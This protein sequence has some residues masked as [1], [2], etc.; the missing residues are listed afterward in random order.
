VPAIDALPK[1]TSITA[2]LP[3]RLSVIPDPIVSD[4]KART[5]TLGPPLWVTVCGLGSDW[6]QV[7]PDQL[8]P[9]KVRVPEQLRFTAATGERPAS[10]GA[11]RL[12]GAYP[13]DVDT[14]AAGIPGL[15]RA[16]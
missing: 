13:N 6:P 11:V 16:H 7:V 12:A 9:L 8:V 4:W 15:C 2:W 1:T 10:W 3:V 14:H 5:S